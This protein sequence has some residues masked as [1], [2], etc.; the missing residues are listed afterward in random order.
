MTLSSAFVAYVCL[1]QYIVLCR[2]SSSVS[3][4]QHTSQQSIYCLLYLL[5]ANFLYLIA[6]TEMLSTKLSGEQ[7]H[8]KS[9][10][11]HRH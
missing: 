7:L 11:Q 9:Q 10:A 3:D 2:P 8:S 5:L 1:G 4:D 6:R